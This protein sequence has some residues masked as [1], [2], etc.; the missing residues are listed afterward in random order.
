[1]FQETSYSDQLTFF[2]KLR[3]F[4]Y[5]LL[6]CII[7]LGIIGKPPDS[8]SQQTARKH[9]VD[10][11]SQRARKVHESDFFYYDA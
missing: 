5:I 9:G 7:S 6:F 8:R 1:M 4:D 11:S 2:Q 10:L 3:S